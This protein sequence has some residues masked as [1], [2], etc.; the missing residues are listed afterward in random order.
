M[1]CPCM[2]VEKIDLLGGGGGGAMA[3]TDLRG[4]SDGGGDTGGGT[5]PSYTYPSDPKLKCAGVKYA[6]KYNDFCCVRNYG[7]GCKKRNNINTSSSGEGSARALFARTLGEAVVKRMNYMTRD[8]RAVCAPLSLKK[9]SSARVYTSGAVEIV[10]FVAPSNGTY[11]AEFT[12]RR[13]D[14]KYSAAG[15]GTS[16]ENEDGGGGGGEEGGDGDDLAHR[17]VEYGGVEWILDSNMV[18][19]EKYG[20]QATCL[21]AAHVAG[22]LST[23]TNLKAVERF[24]FCRPDWEATVEKMKEKMGGG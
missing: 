15:G 19:P 4:G 6:Q 7:K 14:N 24:C 23:D 9:V 18:R 13:F 1:Y 20:H 3:E 16:G 10:P 2:K 11:F 22:I 17:V 21:N 5:G 8:T 12:R